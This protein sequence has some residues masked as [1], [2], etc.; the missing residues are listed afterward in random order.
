[1]KLRQ[2]IL[3]V[4]SHKLPIPYELSSEHVDEA[5]SIAEVDA[6]DVAR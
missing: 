4:H 5:A 3:F 6:E 1:M 2:K